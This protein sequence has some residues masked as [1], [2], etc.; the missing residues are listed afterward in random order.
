M[1]LVRIDE[2]FITLQ[3][4][5]SCYHRYITPNFFTILIPLLILQI[6]TNVGLFYYF[7]KNNKLSNSKLI[8]ALIIN[9]TILALILFISL[10][11]S[12]RG[13]VCD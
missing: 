7:K 5:A 1:G 9:I 4:E 12:Y 11:K 2:M 3:Y 13:D 8:L 6:I 10:N